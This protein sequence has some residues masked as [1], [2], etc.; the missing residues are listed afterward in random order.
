[1][2]STHEE[3]F[4]I[5]LACL[6]S[7]ADHCMACLKEV[8]ASPG[9]MDKSR[10]SWSEGSKQLDDTCRRMERLTILVLSSQRHQEDILP[11]S[12]CHALLYLVLQRLH[13][14]HSNQIMHL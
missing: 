10:P 6:S 13:Q 2:H 14:K 9:I 1:M 7:T 12:F 8:G 5:H 4:Q 11:Y 3:R